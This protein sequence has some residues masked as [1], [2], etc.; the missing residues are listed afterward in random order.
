MDCGC[1]GLDHRA[2]L[3][4]KGIWQMVNPVLVPIDV[5]GKPALAHPVTKGNLD[6]VV[7][8]G[9]LA[10]IALPAEKH[11]IHTDPV[12]YLEPGNLFSHLRYHPRELMAGTGG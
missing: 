9:S 10:I 6:A 11:R 7:I 4:G 2:L 12:F 1:G 3:E 5:L 8:L